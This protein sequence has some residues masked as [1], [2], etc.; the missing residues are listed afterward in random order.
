MLLTNWMTTVPGLILLAR[1]LYEAWQTKTLNWNDL[2]EALIGVGL[3]SAKDFN[4]VGGT[5]RQ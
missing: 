5:R 2:Q 3:V 4:V 1:V